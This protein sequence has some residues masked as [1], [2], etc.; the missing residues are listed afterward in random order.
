MIS[1]VQKGVIKIKYSSPDNEKWKLQL[2]VCQLENGE[3][4]STL[5][6]DDE[7]VQL[8]TGISYPDRR[9]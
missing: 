6:R 7:V 2:I 4:K 1:I 8:K 9:R 5:Y 3:H